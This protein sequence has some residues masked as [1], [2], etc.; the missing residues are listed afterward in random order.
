[1]VQKFYSEKLNKLFDSEE[2]CLKQEEIFDKE[3]AR[4]LAIKENK[5]IAAKELEEEKKKVDAAYKAADEAYNSFIEK[6]E[7]FCEEYNEPFRTTC[8][9]STF[10][11]SPRKLLDD[12][13]RTFFF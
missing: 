11:T 9:P 10:F 7:N 13:F 2:E 12:I 6:L 4:K 5:R 8:E 3:E 1:M